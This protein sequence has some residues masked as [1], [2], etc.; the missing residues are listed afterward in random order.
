M[1]EKPDNRELTEDILI[2]EFGRTI[3]NLDKA[4]LFII[5]PYSKEAEIFIPAYI[6]DNK[7]YERCHS[8]DIKYPNTVEEL[9]TILSI[10]KVEI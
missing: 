9:K 3:F 2:R 5:Y 6:V 7:I 8:I 1:P 4:Q 10:L